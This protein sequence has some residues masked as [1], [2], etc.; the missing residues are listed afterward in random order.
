MRCGG[1]GK[2]QS[3][4]GKVGLNSI[5]KNL[6]SQTKNNTTSFSLFSAPP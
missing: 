5:I 4:F 1:E 6:E 2:R 3:M